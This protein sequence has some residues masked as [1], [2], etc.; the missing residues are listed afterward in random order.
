MSFQLGAVFAVGWV[1]LVSSVFQRSSGLKTLDVI[2]N[3]T[4]TFEAYVAAVSKA[5]KATIAATIFGY[6]VTSVDC[7]QSTSPRCLQAAS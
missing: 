3:K 4:L 2:L 1:A 5:H 7:F 6:Y